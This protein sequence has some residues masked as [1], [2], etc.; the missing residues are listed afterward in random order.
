MSW[1]PGWEGQVLVELSC[2]ELTCPAPALHPNSTG[3][4]A[5]GPLLPRTPDTL[6]ALT[7]LG[8]CLKRVS[9]QHLC[10]QKS[11]TKLEGFSRELYRVSSPGPEGGGSCYWSKVRV[12][13]RGE[14]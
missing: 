4:G 14:T 5:R 2:R 13:S 7:L 12:N 6:R 1:G 9:R 10:E 3:L 11:Q 8:E